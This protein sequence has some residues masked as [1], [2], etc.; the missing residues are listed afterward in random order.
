MNNFHDSCL[1]SVSRY[2]PEKN[3][4][5]RSGLSWEDGSRSGEYQTRIESHSSV[6]PYFHAQFLIRL[7]FDTSRYFFI[8]AS[9]ALPWTLK[10]PTTCTSASNR[11]QNKSYYSFGICNFEWILFVNLGRTILK[12]SG[13]LNN[14]LWVPK[15]FL[16]PPRT[17]LSRACWPYPGMD[18]VIT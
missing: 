6:S 3:H 13:T 10:T 11:Y 7:C 18:T 14:H 16:G 9:W 12:K 15:I 1:D 5:S 4:R 17:L 8:Y 2:G